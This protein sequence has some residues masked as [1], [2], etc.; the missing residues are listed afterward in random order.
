MGNAAE[1][2]KAIERIDAE[3]VGPMLEKLP[4]LGDFKILITSDHATPVA[5]KTHTPSAVPFAMATGE[6]LK[7]E[8]PSI[9]YGETEAA[10]SG[11]SVEHGYTVISDLL[12]YA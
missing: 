4:A 2:V 10:K 6:R 5:L 12:K 9:K 3:V 11:V 7:Q 1:K 8:K